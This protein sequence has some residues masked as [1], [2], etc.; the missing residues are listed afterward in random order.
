MTM[1]AAAA[2][3][4]SAATAQAMEL[5]MSEGMILRPHLVINSDPLN[6]ER[7]Y[8]SRCRNWLKALGR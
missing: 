8:K 6:G 2:T 7:A 3:R 4:G 5:L 1:T